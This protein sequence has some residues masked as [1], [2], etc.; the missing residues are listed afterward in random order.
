MLQVALFRNM[1]L[2][3]GWSPR[4]GAALEAAFRDAGATAVRSFQTNGT[5][6]FD[7]EG[8]TDE[9]M[10]AVADS[11]ADLSGYADLC[12]VVAMD[13]LARMVAT[14]RDSVDLHQMVTFFDPELGSVLADI[15]TLASGPGWVIT[16]FDRTPDDPGRQV[17][18]RIGRQATTRTFGTVVRLCRALGIVA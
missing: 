11:L 12:V 14:H 4:T 17:L 8:R 1:N 13:D 2:G 7:A 6:A 3:Q 15:E 16:R 10:A 9:V 18:A 5:V